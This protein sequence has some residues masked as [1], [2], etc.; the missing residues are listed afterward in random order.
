MFQGV[1]LLGC[2][3]CD[4]SDLCYN[5]NDQAY[6]RGRQRLEGCI[7]NSNHTFDLLAIMTVIV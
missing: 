3:C 2:V 4:I 5:C 1:P 6:E 7:K